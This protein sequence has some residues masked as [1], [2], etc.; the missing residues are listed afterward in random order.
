MATT[1]MTIPPMPQVGGG[2]TDQF[3][4]SIYLAEPLMHYDHVAPLSER[5]GGSYPRLRATGNRLT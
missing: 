5:Y 2:L 3:C 4:G 1:T